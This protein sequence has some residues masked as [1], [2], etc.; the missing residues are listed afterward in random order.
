MAK[1]V[2]LVKF[3]TFAC[4]ILDNLASSKDEL[5]NLQDSISALFD[6]CFAFPSLAEDVAII[7]ARIFL[8]LPRYRNSPKTF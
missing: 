6:I 1:D 8:S 7:I 5:K 4:A 3:G 2:A